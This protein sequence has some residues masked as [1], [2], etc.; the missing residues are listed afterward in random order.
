MV[1]LEAA[2]CGVPTV[3]FAVTGVVDAIQD[4]CTGLL[5]PEGDLS[6]VS[7]AMSS[8]LTD[9]ARRH[10]LGQAGA[11][12]VADAFDQEVVWGRWNALLE[13]RE[14]TSQGIGARA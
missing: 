2:A 14:M 5:V 4:Q 11:A 3:G 9:E 6:G 12:R 13:R 1:A 8:L 10:A 7:D